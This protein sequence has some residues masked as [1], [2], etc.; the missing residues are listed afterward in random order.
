M[1]GPSI[2]IKTIRHV[3]QFYIFSQ[4]LD[5]RLFCVKGI[6]RDHAKFSPVGKSVVM[7]STIFYVL[8]IYTWKIF[9]CY[10]RLL[11]DGPSFGCFSECYE[12][13]EKGSLLKRSK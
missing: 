8:T 7:Y 12:P 3:S 11:Y 9:H 2:H 13:P 5:L 4:E 10:V 6:G 1:S